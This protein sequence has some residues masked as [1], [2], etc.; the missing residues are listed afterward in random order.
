MPCRR[1]GT[2]LTDQDLAAVAEFKAY[3]ADRQEQQQG[4]SLAGEGPQ[5]LSR[6]GEGADPTVPKETDA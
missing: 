4:P 5:V 2:R 1:P 3:L 6:L